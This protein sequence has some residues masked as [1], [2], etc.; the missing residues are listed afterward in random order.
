MMPQHGLELYE[1]RQR[2]VVL[3][4]H[5]ALAIRR[6]VDEHGD[7]HAPILMLVLASLERLRT[8]F[9]E[10]DWFDPDRLISNNDPG[11]CCRALEP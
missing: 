9:R 11:R 4:V 1:Y 7:L 8:S 6:E 5:G 3:F 2:I 10:T